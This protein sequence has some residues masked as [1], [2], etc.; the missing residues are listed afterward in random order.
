VTSARELMNLGLLHSEWFSYSHTTAQV[1]RLDAVLG[2]P[3][4]HSSERI[5]TDLMTGFG[6]ELEQVLVRK[7]CEAVEISPLDTY[8]LISGSQFNRNTRTNRAPGWSSG[9]R[10]IDFVIVDNAGGTGQLAEDSSGHTPVMAIEAKFDAY[11]NGKIGYCTIHEGYSNQVICYP[12]GCMNSE[13]VAPRVKFLWLGLPL[14]SDTKGPMWAARAITEAD[15][16]RSTYSDEFKALAT[17]GLGEQR[18]SEASWAELGWPTIWNGVL[19]FL[20][21]R[22]IAAE[23]AESVLRALGATPARFNPVVAAS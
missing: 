22:D 10:S 9:S 11:V 16:Q 21:D 4:A 12:R 19:G 1:A 18:A 3:G 15:L 7:F 14:K 23:V 6:N 2:T 5:A 17:I 20:R 13:L 8:R